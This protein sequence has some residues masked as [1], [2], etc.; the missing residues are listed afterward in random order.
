MKVECYL[1][2]SVIFFRA[3]LLLSILSISAGSIAAQTSPN[4]PA[5]LFRKPVAVFGDPAFIGTASNPLALAASGPNLVEGREF[6]APQGVALDTTVSPPILYVADTGNHRVM[7]FQFPS[8]LKAGSQADLIIGQQ[9]RFQNLS[10]TF[11][12]KTTQLTAPTGIAVDKSGNLYVADTG[13]NRIL[14][15]PRPFAQPPGYQIADLILGQKSFVVT[16]PNQGRSTPGPDTL[17]TAS[18]GQLLGR[19]SLTFDPQGNLWVTDTGNNRVIRFGVATLK[20]NP[21]N[22]PNADTVLGQIDFVGTT[23][24]TSV[25][26]KVN[27]IRPV[28]LAFDLAGRLFVVDQAGRVVVYPVGAGTNTAAIRIL[29]LDPAATA[30]APTQ[31]SLFNPQA[32]AATGS[33]VVVTDSGNNRL[34]IY[35]PLE[36][37]APETTQFSPS[38]QAVIGQASFV[39]NKAN[40]GAGDASA[41]SLNGPRDI[42]SSGSEVFVADALNH[43]ILVFASSPTGITGTASRVIGQLDFPYFGQ[44]L[45]EGREFNF[46]G[47]G[48]LILDY[49]SSPPHLYV[50]DTGNNRILGFKDFTTLKNGQKA[51]L[52]IGQPDFFRSM[53]NYPSNQAT[54][55]NAQSLSSP[56]SLVVD[57]AGN[58]Y[59]A[60]AG[61]SRV[62]RFPSPFNSGQ[63]SLQTADLVIGQTSFTSAVTDATEKTMSQPIGVALTADA[64]NNAVK[65][66]GW[67]VVADSAH[68]RVL[69]FQKPFV[70]GMAASKVL[71][72]LNFSSTSSSGDPPR[73]STPRGVA[74]DPQDRVLVVDAGNNRHTVLWIYG[75]GA[76]RVEALRVAAT[77]RKSVV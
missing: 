77:D 30:T 5:T 53:V 34:M 25:V 42:I 32:V 47:F 3:P 10:G 59:V 62:L 40:Q 24:P 9:D 12:A 14:R 67:L 63:T 36:N 39:V 61:N 51:D 17:A 64:F 43:R 45:I 15:Y 23:A 44:N 74:V 18:A 1:E 66:A 33:G 28:G 6:S 2:I 65:D 49:S 46:A 57:S 4:F 71:G 19:T 73:V 8:Q 54:Q 27:L 35:P 29:G 50:C 76:R 13:N 60:D 58:L 55:P 72:Q 70:S 48:S 26:S 69:F 68:N 7:A 31:I 75:D 16:S 37:W 41:S 21:G 38:A 56:T 22:A 11:F 52:V 20:G